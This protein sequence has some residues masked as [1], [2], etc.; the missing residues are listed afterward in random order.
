LVREFSQAETRRAAPI[1][2]ADCLDEN[3]SMARRIAFYS[4]LLDLH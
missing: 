4:R 1:E 2:V 3:R